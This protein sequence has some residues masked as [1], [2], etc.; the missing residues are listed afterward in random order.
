MSD[1]RGA[2]P[3]ATVSADLKKSLSKA[4]IEFTSDVAVAGKAGI[5]VQV[6]HTHQDEV[7]S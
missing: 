3:P 4:L 1:L 5:L 2:P 7:T 6:R